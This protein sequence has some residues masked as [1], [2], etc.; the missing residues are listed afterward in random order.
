[1]KPSITVMKAKMRRAAE[2]V[3]I[4]VKGMNISQVSFPKSAMKKTV[5]QRL[6]G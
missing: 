5:Q 4:G 3:L 1:M 6:Y 2:L